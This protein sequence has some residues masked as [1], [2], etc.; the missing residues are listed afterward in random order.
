MFW[1]KCFRL[2]L[3]KLINLLRHEWNSLGSPNEHLFYFCLNFY[4]LLFLFLFWGRGPTGGDLGYTVNMLTWVNA[5][6]QAP[7]AYRAVTQG[8]GPGLGQVS[9]AGSR[10]RRPNTRRWPAGVHRKT[11]TGHGS[12]RAWARSNEREEAHPVVWAVRPDVAGDVVGVE[13]SGGRVQAKE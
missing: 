7:G 13:L 4:I 2:E 8:G 9:M 1:I 3:T 6:K 10:S 11:C 5:V 12:M